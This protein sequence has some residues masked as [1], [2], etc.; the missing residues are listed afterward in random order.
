MKTLID[1]LTG[2]LTYS[3]QWAIYAERID[4]KF[5]PESPARLGQRQYDNGGVWDNCEQ[6]ANNE[7]ATDQMWNYLGRTDGRDEDTITANDER[8]AAEWL[9]EK[10]NEGY[11]F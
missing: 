10:I 1:I 7:Y 3:N 4:G 9:I 6:F 11:L 8:E 2:T 5:A